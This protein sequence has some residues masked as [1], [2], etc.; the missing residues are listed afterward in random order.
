MPGALY[1]GITVEFGVKDKN[2]GQ[3]MKAIDSEARELQ[4]SLNNVNKSLKFNESDPSL[5]A[6]KFTLINEQ[7][8][9]TKERL[10]QLIEYEKIARE[11]F[12]NG[13]ISKSQYSSLT[14]EINKA[15]IEIQ[16]L[17][18]DSKDAF[19]SLK[20][21][22]L[23][24]KDKLSEFT[25]AAIAAGTALAVNKLK[26]LGSQAIETASDLREVQNVVDTSFGDLAY[27]MED[28]ADK[29]IEVYGISKL[30]A[31]QTGSTFMAMARGMDIVPQTAAE[32][33]IALTALSADM[34]SF[35]N[36]EQQV[37][38]TA[39]NSVF[40]GE[41]ET[42]KKFGI[43]MTEANLNAFAM[44]QGIEKTVK[45]MSQAEKVQLRYNY[46]MSQTSLV[47]GDFA[48]TSGEWANRSRVLKEQITELSAMVGEELINNLG[49]VQ[50]KADDLFELVRE[51]KQSGQ[52]S[53]IIGDVT[54]ALN[55]L[56]DI[57][58][59]ATEFIYKYRVE[60]GNTVKAIIALKAVMKLSGTITN[61]IK[62]L[63]SLKSAMAAL[64][65]ATQAQTAAQGALNAS[66]AV[67]PYVLL[68]TAVTALAS[69]IG[70]K[71]VKSTIEAD[72]AFLKMGKT[73][74]VMHQAA[75][76]ADEFADSMMN[77]AKSRA[78]N[79]SSIENEY[80]GYKNLA[81]QLFELTDK[82]E[83]SADDYKQINTLVDSLNQSM[84]GLGLSFDNTTGS[85]NMQQ[86][87]LKKLIGDYENYYKTIAVQESLTQL[88]QDQYEAEKKLTQA[89]EDQQK[90]LESFQA[91]EQEVSI[92]TVLRYEDNGEEELNRARA[93]R[94]E[95]ARTYQLA[96]QAADELS[97]TYDGISKE[98]AQSTKYIS[99]NAEASKDMA[100]KIAD[101]YEEQTA[102]AE[103][104]AESYK[105]AADAVKDY[106]SALS[107]L[108]TL[109]KD[110][111]EGNEMSSLEM[112]DLIDK[113][114]ELAKQ[115][116][117]AENGYTLEKEAIEELI[118]VKARNMELS[119]QEAA[120]SKR[121]LLQ[122]AGLSSNAI[123][124]LEQGFD[125]G[126]IKD[127]ASLQAGR[128]TD[129]VREYLT[130]Y[131]K[132]KG[133]GSIINDILQDGVKQGGQSTLDMAS[134]DSQFKAHE[135]AH[136]MGRKSDEEYYS[137]LE[138]LNNKY[139]KNSRDNLD[140]YWSYEEKIYAY[141]KKAADD[142]AK[143]EEKSNAEIAKSL[144]SLNDK[145]NDVIDA[146]NELN[147]IK[148]NKSV[149]AYDEATGFKLEADQ[150][151]LK[152]AYDK[153]SKAQDTLLI[154]KL[155]LGNNN[156]E[157]ISSLKKMVSSLE[158]TGIKNILPDLGK[159]YQQLGKISTTTNNNKTYN[160]S[161]GDV[162]TDGSKEDFESQ[163]REFLGEL[164]RKAERE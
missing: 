146:R 55:K 52:L 62:V 37:A 16:S 81:A 162:Y 116:R 71:L 23:G 15:R 27:M 102:S 154:E 109:Q 101:A 57:L 98:I 68:I 50:S 103:E 78:E 88:Y 8:D 87:E 33:S 82:Q 113:Y 124:I 2:I 41:T 133:I 4:K 34:A 114:P 100:E 31:K 44:A 121:A 22:I 63:G 1:K 26:D 47:Q 32:M 12:E 123:S 104:L 130:A 163:L 140:K 29:A 45:Q 128:F 21:S 95:A 39:L 142:L 148:N 53:R 61:V 65:T 164:I 43:V 79:V 59:G 54:A 147:G 125:N 151:K 153:L 145:I 92:R 9:T 118:K 58:V 155:G 5:L 51:A 73:E 161:F 86:S 56:I 115:I 111:S 20:T 119:A 143:A 110:I 93:Q 134:A 83:K 36:T 132:E 139:Y 131:A 117:S 84:Q 7:I 137:E 17:E 70:I 91:A 38:S 75:Q 120:E 156:S 64:T 122:Q 40:T 6:Q 97:G 18:H 35:Y 112:L 67:N 150:N 66:M 135:H 159:A 28:L 126:A 14:R 60:I 107:G 46:V 106:A 49:D 80:D 96:K 141:R 144:I 105:T 90:A 85:L 89:K 72:K 19:N 30:T 108:V 160:L 48:K 10:K 77:S 99:E 127:I 138:A 136:N 69:A 3:T 157:I 129:D 158:N 152:N 74:E 13:T 24:A 25:K 11:Q 76:A 94:D 42:L 149:L